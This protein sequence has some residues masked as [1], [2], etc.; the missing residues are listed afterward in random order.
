MKVAI[1]KKWMDMIK[2]KCSDDCYI[3][4]EAGL[5]HNGSLEVAKALIDVAA[6]AGADAVK[7]QKRTI[8]ML[9]VKS[10]LDAEDDRFPKF[11]KTYR[12]IREHLEFSLEEYRELKAYTQAKGLDFIVTAFDTDAV[13]F[14]EKLG[15]DVYKLASHSVTNLELLDYL[16][17]LR[18]PIVLS[19][20]M[21]ELDELDRA[22]E[23]IRRHDTPLVLLHCVSAY[24]TPLADCNLEMIDVLKERYRLPVG[25][26]GHELGYLPTV[27]AVGMG[28]QV[29]ERH[30][31]LD[32]TMVGF[33]H[34][35]SLEPD[36]LIAMVRD[37]RNVRKIR[38][39]G[40]KQVSETEW[41]T[42]RKYHVSMAS[43]VAIPAGTTLT[44]VMVSYRNPGTGIPA[45]LAHTVLG[46]RAARDISVDE[47][48]S[49]EMFE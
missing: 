46:K 20:G 39:T 13:D 17:S 38:G 8:E 35:M 18:K 33:D 28:A 14:L 24:P 4:A 31:T 49:V 45:K 41:I 11:G 48:L 10:V 42:R 6:I 1:M 47:L 5:N 25:Y 22:I 36:E 32:K 2:G 3:I 19:T 27:V 26:S 16:A 37:I 15:V 40:Q 29:V 43:A 30:F 23:I 12:E 9:A 7:F 21:A 44:E 34:K